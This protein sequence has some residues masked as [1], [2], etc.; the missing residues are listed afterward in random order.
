MEGL[1]HTAPAAATPAPVRTR[2][3]ATLRPV[4]ADGLTN[5]FAA[6]TRNRRA[7]TAF[8]TTCIFLSEEVL[9]KEIYLVDEQD[10]VSSSRC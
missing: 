6:P 1:L 4:K 5:A 10:L 2:P 9:S 3:A 8:I 7:A